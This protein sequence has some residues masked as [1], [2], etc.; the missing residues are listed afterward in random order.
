MFIFDRLAHRLIHR[1]TAESSFK[2]FIEKT[3]GS[4]SRYDINVHAV[5]VIAALRCFI[6][7]ALIAFRFLLLLFS[8]LFPQEFLFVC[9][10]GGRVVS[11]SKCQ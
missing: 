4:F 7:N 1:L 5:S 8:F 6:N 9:G 10:S 3:K 11:V 2:T